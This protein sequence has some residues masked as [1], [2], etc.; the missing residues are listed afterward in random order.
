MTQEE[1]QLLLRDICMRL[2]HGVN[3]Y[4]EWSYPD[5]ER[6]NDSGILLDI[7]LFKDTILFKRSSGNCTRIP[8]NRIDGVVKPYLRQMSSMTEKEKEVI[9]NL[10]YNKESIFTSPIPVW[11]INESDIEEYIDFCNSHHLD[12]R[13]LIEMGLALEAPDGMYN[14]K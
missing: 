7:D 12:W 6:K 9:N 8:F 10:I 11:V 2:P 3:V 5:G 4:C 13:G 14:F 1:R